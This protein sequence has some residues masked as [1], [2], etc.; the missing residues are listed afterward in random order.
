MLFS[1]S[2]VKYKSNPKI[3]FRAIKDQEGRIRIYRPQAHLK[4]LLN[5]AQKSCLPAFDPNEFLKCLSRL[6]HVDQDWVPSKMGY[7]LYVRSSFIS[8]TVNFS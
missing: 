5:S 2:K 4:S 3:A 8:M 7:S 6:L 1:Y